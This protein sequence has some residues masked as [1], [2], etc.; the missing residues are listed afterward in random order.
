MLYFDQIEHDRFGTIGQQI[1]TLLH[2][3]LHVAMLLTVE[4][5]T[6]LITWSAVSQRFHNIEHFQSYYNTTTVGTDRTAVVESL[7]K[8]LASIQDTLLHKGSVAEAFNFTPVLTEI[9]RLDLTSEYGIRE[10]SSLL[11]EIWRAV[12]AYVLTA[13]GISVPEG[14]GTNVSS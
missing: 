8:T 6:K 14:V 11:E 7:N 5:N 9:S 10:L 3:P 1:W 12:L 13:F 2:F 4:G